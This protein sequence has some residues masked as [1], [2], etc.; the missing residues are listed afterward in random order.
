MNPL[1][2]AVMGRLIHSFRGYV[3]IRVWGYSPERFL[4]LCGNKGILLWGIENHGESYEMYVS[5][6]G[7]FCLRPIVKKTKTRVAVLN[8]YGLPFFVPKIKKRSVF[9][10]G[11]LGCLIFLQIMSQFIWTIDFTGNITL[12]DD[13]LLDFLE[14]RQII[15]G[16][17]K[18][19]L[20]PEEL[21]R[22]I[23]K[24][25]DLV[26]WTSARI[27]GTK[28]VIQIKEN[29][30]P[31]P[32]EHETGDMGGMDLTADKKGRIVNMITRS[33]VPRVK[34]GDDVE[35]GQLL[36]SGAVPVYNED[37]TVKEYLLCRADAD[38]YLQCDCRYQQKIPIHYLTKNYTGREKKIPY[39]RVGS[40]EWK[41]PVS[42]PDYLKKDCVVKEKQ[43]ALLQNL[44]LPIAVGNC[45]YREYVI[46]ERNHSKEQA[47]ELCGEFLDEILEGFRQKGVQIIRKD[48]TI[49][50]DSVNYILTADFTVVEKTGTLVVTQTEQPL[51]A[52]EQEMTAEE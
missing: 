51:P 44:F 4:N 24:N 26:T 16:M 32:D 33:G 14:T 29:T 15:C 34:I 17:A 31:N 41:L 7:F 47:K 6:K 30:H 25:F 5:I 3:R 8:R 35:A 48:V 21:E 23:R 18:K 11:L 13:V 28:L 36:V 22:D 1:R 39:L 42:E 46:E 20:K 10:A 37:A 40:R 50:K 2:E 43:A 38:I 12:T 27:E 52:K 19:D 49:K 9:A 45:Q